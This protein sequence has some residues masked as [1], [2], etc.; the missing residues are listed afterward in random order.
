[1]TPEQHPAPE[2]LEQFLRDDLTPTEQASMEQHVELCETCRQHLHDTAA[3]VDWWDA[4]SEFLMD[5]E[6]DDAT[7]SSS[8]LSL[9]LTSPQSLSEDQ[10]GQEQLDGLTTGMRQVLAWLAPTDD[11]SMLGRIGGYEISGIIGAGG[12]GVVLKG[13]DRSLNRFVAIKTLAPHLAT[14]GAARRR[15]AREAQAAA[16]VVHDNVIAIHGVD[17]ANGLPYLVMPFLRGASLQKRIN[18]VG[19]LSVSEI[20]RIGM[21]TARGLAAAHDQGLVHRDI[22][23]ANILLDGTTDRVLLTDF[24]LARAADDAGLT[25]SGVIAGTPHFMS[26]EQARGD[27]IDHRS[28]IFSLGSVLYTLSSG[29]PPFRASGNWG[30]LRKVTDAEPRSLRE[31]NSDIPNWLEAIILKC[32]CKDPDQRFQS[33]HALDELLKECLAHHQQPTQNPLPVEAKTLESRSRSFANQSLPTNSIATFASRHR[34]VITAGL[35]AVL[36]AAGWMLKSVW[37]NSGAAETFESSPQTIA[38]SNENT[39]QDETPPPTDPLDLQWE[40]SINLELDLLKQR[41]DQ[42]ESADENF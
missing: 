23:P 19:A 10:D 39:T 33:A 3:S 38:P 11:P 30:I 17:E 6:L 1:M 8:Q 12:M 15:F 25:H 14:S 29:R 16:A 27:A 32:L 21:Q 42:L 40:N 35:V 36:F 4:V 13:F 28:D 18:A 7:E 41:L 24:G 20:L 34:H 5:D 9:S 2:Q 37:M 22:K 31:L 26:P